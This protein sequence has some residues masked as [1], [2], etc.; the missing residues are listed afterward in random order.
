MSIPLINITQ[1]ISKTFIS[2][3][4]KLQTHCYV[5][6]FLIIVII[7]PYFEFQQYNI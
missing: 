2:Q 6:A 3:R 4:D 5:F 1:K 7:I